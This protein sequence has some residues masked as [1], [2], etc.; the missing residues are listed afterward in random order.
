MPKYSVSMMSEEHLVTMTRE[1]D[2]HDEFSAE[3]CAFQLFELET[4]KADPRLIIRIEE[5]GKPR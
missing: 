4:Q 5:I 1:I 3:V 2:A